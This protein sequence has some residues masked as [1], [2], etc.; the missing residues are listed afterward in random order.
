METMISCDPVSEQ[1]QKH[2]QITKKAL[3]KRA[4]FCYSNSEKWN[5]IFVSKKPIL[6][7]FTLT[8]G[9]PA[10]LPNSEN[11]S[12]SSCPNSIIPMKFCFKTSLS[13]DSALNLLQK[14]L[15]IRKETDLAGPVISLAARRR[16]LNYAIF[17]Y[18]AQRNQELV[19]KV[20]W[21]KYIQGWE[22][23]WRK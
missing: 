14:V 21:W 16:C 15:E 7:H 2:S 9:I 11:I 1:L 12:F 13:P 6:T 10:F 22:L 17:F 8:A 20:L 23:A 18:L 3:L 4:N 5:T 19:W